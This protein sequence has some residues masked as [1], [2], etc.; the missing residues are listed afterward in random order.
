[1]TATVGT[2]TPTM[3]STTTT[4]EMTMMCSAMA[5]DATG[6]IGMAAAGTTTMLAMKATDTMAT[7]TEP[8]FMLTNSVVEPA[9]S[10]DEE[11]QKTSRMKK[12]AKMQPT[13]SLTPR[14]AIFQCIH[15]YSS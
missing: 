4:T 7:L 10:A 9:T 5:T 3:P 13:S 1:M 15:N 8:P 6:T 14:Y 12:G 11:R 2:D